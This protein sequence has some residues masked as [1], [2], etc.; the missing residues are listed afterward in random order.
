MTIKLS[1]EA[2]ARITDAFARGSAGRPANVA[3]QAGTAAAIGAAINEVLSVVSKE[4]DALKGRKAMTFRGAYDPGEHYQA[5]DVTQRSGAA[6][7]CMRLHI[8]RAWVFAALAE[9]RSIEGMK[10]DMESAWKPV[11]TFGDTA[12]EVRAAHE[13]LDAALLPEIRRQLSAVRHPGRLDWACTSEVL[14]N[15]PGILG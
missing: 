10:M 3:G 14:D 4:M 12:E 9:V 11:C 2:T 13:A 1:K 8:R 5:G 6:W 7:V 15:A